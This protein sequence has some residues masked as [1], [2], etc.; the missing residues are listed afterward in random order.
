MQINRL[1]IT[2]AITTT[3]NKKKKKEK[4]F[5]PPEKGNNKIKAELRSINKEKEN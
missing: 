4:L 1:L 2:Q 5:L 3:F